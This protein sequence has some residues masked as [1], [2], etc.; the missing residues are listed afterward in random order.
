MDQTFLF[1]LS[2]SFVIGGFWAIIVSVIADKLGSKIGG[3][4]AGFPSTLLF[5]LLFI[6][7]TQNTPAAVEAATIIPIEFGVCAVFLSA[8]VFFLRNNIWF[9]LIISLTIWL[10]LS[11]VFVLTKFNNFLLS[12][13]GYIILFCSSYF[14]LEKILKIR[15]LKGRKINYTFFTL[16]LRGL[17]TGTIVALAVAFAKLS[18]PLIGGVFSS[19]PAIFT[20]TLIIVFFSQGPEFSQAFAKSAVIST[21]SIAV[22]AMAVRFTYGNSGIILGT[23]ISAA[24][25]ILSS[26]VVFH[27]LIKRAG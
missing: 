18:G 8:Y 7:W 14:F 21:I 2:L 23:V 26:I 19:F 15:S 24:I 20:S 16:L 4:I 22:Y 1:K 12:I 17:L 6:A 11:S 3:L 27:L 25:S 5:G 13:I 10:V 9:S